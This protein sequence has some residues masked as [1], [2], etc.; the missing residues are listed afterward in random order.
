MTE[1]RATYRDVFA[2]P[3]FR[4]L[5]LTR[6]LAIGADTL[7]MLALS[8]L[9]FD[10]TG[11]PLLTA[12]TFGIGFVPQVVGGTL[13]G[14][15]ADR[16]R[17]RRLIVSGYLLEAVVA[18]ALG[19]L[20]LPVGVSLAMVAAIATLMPVFG[21]ASNR[22]IAE[23]LTGDAYVLGRSVSSVAS[24]GAQLVGLAVG[25]AAVA[26]I[27][28]QRAL[29][30]TAGCHLVVAVWVRL[31]LPAYPRPS[32]VTGSAIR[33]SWRV[34]GT[35][36]RDPDIRPLLLVQ[37]LPP[38]FLTGAE[39]L[40]VPYVAD[41]GYPSGVAGLVLACAPVGMVV[42]NLVLG[43]LVRP[44]TRER[45][46]A[47]VII[48]LGLPLALLAFPVPVPVI[49]LVLLVAGATFCYSLGIQRAFLVAVPE[50]F[51]GQGFALFTTGL[52][53]LQ[54]V[55][56]VLTGGVAQLVSPGAAMAF[57]GAAS[58][59]VGL[60]WWLRRTRSVRHVVSPHPAAL[61]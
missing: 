31:R 20:L 32:A 12:V 18:A 58:A 37:W 7:R 54:G 40:V 15:L 21:G 8:V 42:S 59:T 13:F 14:A 46:V 52:M 26:A 17:P 35:L 57:A 47:P 22:L 39:A 45:L 28:P 53:T 19:L 60:W 30:V 51:R 5:F 16:L 34:T 11:S 44:D 25:G 38:T 56:P 1:S 55:G 27:G 2:E 41:R 49:G 3:V 43:R 6:S 24:G 9:V 4:T 50:Q 61:G 23:A 10:R 33:Q 48:A 29:L 36:L